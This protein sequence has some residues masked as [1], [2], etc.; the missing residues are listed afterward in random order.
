MKHFTILE[1]N[2]DCESPM[3]GTIN[4]IEDSIQSFEDFN[5]RS[6]KAIRE[7]FDL[8]TDTSQKNARLV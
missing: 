7:H 6:I 4:N 2:Q 1:L 3:I 5:T 8:V